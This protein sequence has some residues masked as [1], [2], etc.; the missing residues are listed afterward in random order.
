[1]EHVVCKELVCH[2][3]DTNIISHLQHGFQ[4]GVSS[5]TQLISAIHD[6]DSVLNTHGQVD[7][8]FLDFAKAFDSDS[9]SLQSPCFMEYVVR[10]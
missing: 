2:L 7:V 9:A 10:L 3:T 6:C 1:M 8:T 4:Q 5:T